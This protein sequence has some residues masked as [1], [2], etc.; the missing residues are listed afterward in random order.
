MFAIDNHDNQK[1]TVYG[2]KKKK[3]MIMMINLFAA[4][5]DDDDENSLYKLKT[6][7]THKSIYKKE[8]YHYKRCKHQLRDI[9]HKTH[10]NLNISCNM[11]LKKKKKKALKT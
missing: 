9:P 5:N 8:L 1:T 6:V 10:M 11:N 2:T 3:M 4:V 7:L